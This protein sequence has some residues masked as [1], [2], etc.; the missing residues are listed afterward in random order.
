MILEAKY[1]RDINRRKER[2]MNQLKMYTDRRPSA[3]GDAYVAIKLQ[4]HKTRKFYV[5][6]ARRLGGVLVK[7]AQR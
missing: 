7:Q 4:L 5:A 2:W 6:L 3:N 1:L